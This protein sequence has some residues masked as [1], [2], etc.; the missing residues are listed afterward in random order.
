MKK[1]MGQA[2]FSFA[3]KQNTTI[4]VVA[5]NAKLSKTEINKVSQMAHNGIA[6]TIQPAHTMLDGDTIFAISTNKKKSDVNIVGA[7]AA[8]VVSMAIINA[9][10]SAASAGGLPSSSERGSSYKQDTK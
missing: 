3:T 4:G 10:T 1:R 2:V 9:I 7:F 8:E 6:K 5:T